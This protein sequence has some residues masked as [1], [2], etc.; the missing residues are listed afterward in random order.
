M[1]VFKWILVGVLMSLCGSVF[2]ASNG[3]ISVSHFEPLQRLSTQSK[4]APANQKFSTA[5]PPLT[6]NF[7]AFGQS[8][9]LRLE[10]NN[11]FLSA[12]AN[13]ALPAGV[14][15][16]RGSLANNPASW[17]RIVMFEG[18]PRG[19]IWDGQQLY[20]VEAPGDSIVDATASIIYRLADVYIEPGSMTCGSK[21][22][23]GNGSATY[24]ML[25]GEL[26]AAAAAQ[27]PGAVTGIDIGTVADFSFTDGMGGDAA[28]VLAIVDRMNRVDGIFS[29]EIGVQISVPEFDTYSDAALDPFGPETDPGDLLGQV[30]TYRQNTPAQSALGLTHLWTGRDL[31]GTTVGIAFNDVLCR[32]SVGVGLSM[33][34]GSASFDSLVAAH[35]IGHN[36]GAPHDGSAGAC[37]SEPLTFIMAPTIKGETQFSQSSIEI[38]EAN[39]AAASCVTALPTVDMVASSIGSCADGA[40]IVDCDLGEIPGQSNNTVT[41]T[42]TPTLV[43]TGLLE[44]SVTT[45]VDERL[46]NNTESLQLTVDPAVDLAVNSL[47]FTNITLN[48]TSTIVATQQNL[49]ALDATGV[50]LS[51]SFGGNVRAESASWTIGT[52]TC[53]VAAQQIDCQAA[54]FANLSTATLTVTVT[55]LNDGRQDYSVTLSANEADFD[56]S[57]NE[58][59]GTVNVRDPDN[60]GG[61]GGGGIV[62]LTFLWMLALIAIAIQRFSARLGKQRSQAL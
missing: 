9:D 38:M 3:N 22:L 52:G 32:N 44:A 48:A 30:S 31:E 56:L 39:A 43:G 7:D 24:S 62:G 23:S 8:F 40:G 26:N 55:G 13:S 47:P 25:V 15:I 14:G 11:R 61:G 57:N 34:S 33:G 16:Y 36:F 59:S 17:V 46:G 60:D 27:G 53:T 54:T 18:L 1:K 6:L 41:I 10:P 4:D 28:A 20:S 51:A 58:D 42:A 37:E 19:F 50:T 49:S 5:T 35:E 21:S 29:Q 2:A 12:A 45:D